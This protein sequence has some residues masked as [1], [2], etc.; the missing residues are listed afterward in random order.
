MV[1]RLW[2]T[3]ARIEAVRPLAAGLLLWVL[4]GATRC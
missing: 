4:R 2:E 1:S 3:A